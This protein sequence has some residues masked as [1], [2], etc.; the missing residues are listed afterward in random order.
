MAMLVSIRGE[1]F[2]LTREH[3]FEGAPCYLTPVG[4][5]AYARAMEPEDTSQPAP[6]PGGRLK[7]AANR[8]AAKCLAAEIIKGCPPGRER[9]L[10]ITKLEECLMWANASVL[11]ESIPDYENFLMPVENG[12]MTDPPTPPSEPPTRPEPELEPKVED[13]GTI[14]AKVEVETRESVEDPEAEVETRVNADPASR[15]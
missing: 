13:D 5:K 14:E 12:N 4:R 7:I 3:D 9:S 1:V 10:A 8:T 6:D 2:R 11:R 15:T